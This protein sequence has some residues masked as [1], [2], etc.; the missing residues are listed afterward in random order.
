MYNTVTYLTVQVAV[1]NTSTAVLY[2]VYNY[3]E[4]IFWLPLTLTLSLT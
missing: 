4:P 1:T 2:Q 3:T